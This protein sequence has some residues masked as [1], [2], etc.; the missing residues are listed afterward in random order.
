MIGTAMDDFVWPNEL[1]EGHVDGNPVLV[2]VSAFF[3]ET[4]ASN[5]YQRPSTQDSWEHFEYKSLAAVPFWHVRLTRTTC[6]TVTSKSHR[7]CGSCYQPKTDEHRLK[8]CECGGKY[9]CNSV[10]Q[11]KE[12]KRHKKMHRILMTIKKRREEKEASK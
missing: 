5:S 8:R 1:V 3:E 12:W 6:T 7:S 11:K 2:H 10:C 9:Y 4:L